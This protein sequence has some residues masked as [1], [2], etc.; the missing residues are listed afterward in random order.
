MPDNQ[1]I[2][3]TF[4]YVRDH[5]LVDVSKLSPERKKPIQDVRD[6]VERTRLMVAGKNDEQF[7][8]FVSQTRDTER[9]KRGSNE[10]SADKAK[11]VRQKERR[12]S[13]TS[14]RPPTIGR[15]I[16]A[17]GAV[18]A[19]EGIRR[20]QERLQNVVQRSEGA[21]WKSPSLTQRISGTRSEVP[22]TDTHIT[23]H[24]RDDA[25]YGANIKAGDR[26]TD[27]GANKLWTPHGHMPACSGECRCRETDEEQKEVVKAGFHDKIMGFR[28]NLLDCVPQKH[29][30][31][32]TV[33]YEHSNVIVKCQKFDE[34]QQ[35]IC[36]LLG[37]FEK[38]A[39]HGKHVVGM[40]QDSHQTLTEDPVFDSA[41]SEL[42][43]LLEHFCERPELQVLIDAVNADAQSDEGLRDWFHSVLTYIRKT[44]LEPG[45]GLEPECNNKSNRSVIRDAASTV[46]H[47]NN[48]VDTTGSWFRAGAKTRSTR[49]SVMTGVAPRRANWSFALG[50]LDP[51]PH[52]EYTN[53]SL[54]LVVNIEDELHHNIT[55]TMAYI[56]AECATRREEG[57]R[58][59]EVRWDA[60]SS[61]LAAD[62]VFSCWNGLE[63]KI[64]IWR[65]T[66]VYRP[67]RV[68]EKV[69]PDVTHGHSS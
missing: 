36:W 38:Y 68:E 39:S 34:Y 2:D 6:I 63:S 49:A 17:P 41:L 58:T 13:Q 47:F 5:S 64:S 52:I 27:T 12:S 28:D 43:N 25:R 22:D 10:V 4:A 32:A 53:D 51:I 7:Q 57:E 8:N 16:L 62:Y 3:Q 15:D 31:L 65:S 19:A 50:W 9:A 35:F 18:H 37:Y 40:R 69:P 11:A 48:L 30:D 66:R 23:Q 56:Q 46:T 1:A 33:K 14:R 54:D 20:H 67:R 21:R 42:C 44:L 29:K 60:G 59:T 24:P 45:F 26:H 61:S 55:F